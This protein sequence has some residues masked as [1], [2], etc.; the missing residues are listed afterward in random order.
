MWSSSLL[1]VKSDSRTI[2]DARRPL[3]RAVVCSRQV[4]G[5]YF[6]AVFLAGFFA[7]GFLAAGFFAADFFF[8]GIQL[9][10]FFGFG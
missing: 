4:P 1:H 8:A 7:A 6:F 9:L 2:S 3:S 5:I 10:L